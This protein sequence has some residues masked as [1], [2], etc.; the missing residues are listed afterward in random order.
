MRNKRWY[1]IS[2]DIRSQKRWRQ[3]YKQLQGRGERI[4]YS[5]FRCRLNRT[6]MEALR[7]DLEKLLN[8]EDDLM[9]VHLCPSCASRVHVRGDDGKDWGTPP[10][11]FK[12]L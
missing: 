5:L 4:H 10:A 3:A 8:D 1:L 9:F 2:Y 12:V 7:W 6:E 11:R